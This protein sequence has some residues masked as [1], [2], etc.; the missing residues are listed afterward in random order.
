MLK[1]ILYNQIDWVDSEIE[2][3]LNAI[4]KLSNGFKDCDYKKAKRIMAEIES[5]RDDLNKLYIEK[6]AL[7]RVVREYLAYVREEKTND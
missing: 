2:D 4:D 6:E 3:S 1:T 7:Q 5:R